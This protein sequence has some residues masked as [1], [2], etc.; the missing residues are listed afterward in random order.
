MRQPISTAPTS[1]NF[2]YILPCPN[3]VHGHSLE[4]YFTN[5]WSLVGL[6]I[7]QSG[8]PYSI[9][10][11]TGAV[12]SIYYST[13]NGI[14]NPIVP[15]A[16]G[17]TPK[18]AK[19]GKSGAFGTDD[20]ALKASCF[21]VPLLAPG[22]YNGGNPI[23]RCLRDRLHSRSAQYLSSVIPEAA[24]AS[25]IKL[26]T[27]TERYNLKY[28]FDVF[29]LTN[30]TSFD[31]PGNEVSQNENYNSFPDLWSAFVQRPIRCRRR[32]SYHRQR[33]SDSDVATPTFLIS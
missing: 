3:L 22:S 25:L 15:L 21:T 9:I 7:L 8:Q 12:G 29:N 24:D 14:T 31:I 23:N 27:L 18:N 26:T 5:G 30:T 32:H 1:F 20:A 33:A 16:P 10:D 2:N 6:T 4:S 11:F 19:T 17:C 13:N 28:T